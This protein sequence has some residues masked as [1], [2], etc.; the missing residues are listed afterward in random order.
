MTRH[1]R[2]VDRAMANERLEKQ[3]VRSLWVDKV[4]AAAR[5]HPDS[6]QPWFLT[7]SGAEGRDIQLLIEEGLVELTEVNSIADKDK[8]KIVAVENSTIA[9]AALQRKFIG[10]R[11]KEVDFASLVHG[12][13][14]FAWPQGDDEV[15]CRAHVINLDLDTPLKADNRDGNVIFPVLAWVKKLC[16]LHGR[17]PRTDW[18]LCLTLHGEVVWP[19]TVNQWIKSFLL[20]NFKRE[21]KFSKSCQDFFGP[22]L[23]EMINETDEIDF[24]CL[25]SADQQKFIMVMVP[26]LIANFLHTEG[27][28]VHTERCL[29]YGGDGGHAPMATWIVRFTWDGIA[30]ATPDS[31]YRAA[32]QE[33]LSGVGVVNNDGTITQG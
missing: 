3:T 33:V 18:I 24:T 9:A 13:G 5:A 30:T 11:I 7:L 28:R 26:K 17:S 6:N 14:P 4:K 21:P 8:H 31:L 19:E 25:A 29:R 15:Y 2:P 10:L 20:E 32:L 16:L 22:E 27:W 12:D 23:Y 1:K